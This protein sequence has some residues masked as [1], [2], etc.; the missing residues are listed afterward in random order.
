MTISNRS[1]AAERKL[2]MLEPHK[3][4]LEKCVYCPKLCRA[5]CPVSNVEPTESLT[6]W[7]KMSAAYFLGRGDMPVEPDTASV[8]WGCTGCMGCRERCDHKNDVATTLRDTR[9]EAFTRGAAPEAARRVASEHRTRAVAI[10]ARVAELRR[11]EPSTPTAAVLVGCGYHLSDLDAASGERLDALA[12]RVASKLLGGEGDGAV[13]AI[14][15]C[16][17]AP[18][19]DAGDRDGFT[20]AA[21]TFAAAAASAHPLVVADPGC[22]KTI[23]VDYARVGVSAVKPTLLVDLAAQSLDRMTRAAG[24]DAAPPRYHDPCQLARGLGRTEEPRRIL[25]K[26]S[27]AAPREFQRSG[28]MADCSGAG[29]LLPVTM[30]EASREIAARRVGEHREKG[31]GTLVSACASSVRRFRANGERAED[32]IEWMARGLGLT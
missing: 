28:A 3:S 16:C 24:A 6:P 1:P 17:G 27:G 11:G 7:G 14:D 15:V 18:L 9:A 8:A 21:Q 13:R 19:L 29:G 23:A 2:A 31:G 20:R 4:T 12:L 22:A 30:P 32:L 10:A 26:V 5:S 25:E